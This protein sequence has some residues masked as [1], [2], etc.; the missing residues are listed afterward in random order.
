MSLGEIITDSIR[1][2]FSNITNFLIVGILVL[3]AGISNVFITYGISNEALN[4]IGGIIGIIFALKLNIRTY[5][6]NFDG[7]DIIENP[8]QLSMPEYN[9][10]SFCTSGVCFSDPAPLRAQLPLRG[11]QSPQEPSLAKAAPSAVPRLFSE[12]GL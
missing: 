12:S 7:K 1:Y 10:S 11:V 3:L 2:P 4:V 8:N 5:D 6:I 9:S